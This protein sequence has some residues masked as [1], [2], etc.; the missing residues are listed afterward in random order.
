M[1]TSDKAFLHSYSKDIK[2]GD[3]VWWIEWDREGN[4]K[5]ISNKYRGALI[6]FEIAMPPGGERPVV[7]AIVL[8]FGSKKT[9][10]MEPHLLKKETI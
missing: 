8:P 6:D 1:K 7:Y 5:Y 3:L 4:S 10:K 2:I 9:R